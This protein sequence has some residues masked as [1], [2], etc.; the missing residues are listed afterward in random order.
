MLRDPEKRKTYHFEQNSFKTKREKRFCN[1][2]QW[3]R[4]ADEFQVRGKEV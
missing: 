4:C 3:R 2:Q 1:I